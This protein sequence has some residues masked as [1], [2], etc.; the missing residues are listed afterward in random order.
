MK[1]TKIE[2]SRNNKSR[3]TLK[4]LKDQTFDFFNSNINKTNTNDPQF[5]TYIEHENEDDY[6]NLNKISDLD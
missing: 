2:I 4:P 6:K 5:Q 3:N 1:N